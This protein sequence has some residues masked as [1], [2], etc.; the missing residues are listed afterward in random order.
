MGKGKNIDMYRIRRDERRG[1]KVKGK[2]QA[3]KKGAFHCASSAFCDSS[4]ESGLYFRAVCF[5]FATLSGHHKFDSIHKQNSINQEQSHFFCIL[6]SL[7]DYCM[8]VLV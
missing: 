1:G 4:P 7:F 6:G 2:R 3:D 8:A 5:I